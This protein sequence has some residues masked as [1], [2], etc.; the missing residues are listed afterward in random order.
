MLMSRYPRE[1]EAGQAEMS[2]R[3]A[4]I[5]FDGSVVCERCVVADGFGLRFRGL[6]GRRSLAADEGLLVTATSS[7][8]TTFMRFPID[9]LFLDGELRVVDVVA[10]LKPWRL[11]G[12]RRAKQVLELRAGEAARR[13][14]VAGTRLRLIEP[15]TA[16]AAA[17]A[18]GSPRPSAEAA[19]S[20]RVVVGAS[21][22]RFLRV[23]SFLLGR[24]GFSVAS[25]TGFADL[26][27]VVEQ[28]GADVV[29]LDT[30][31]SG[32]WTARAAAALEAWRTDVGVLVVCDES[33]ADLPDAIPKW[34]SFDR[35]VE[36]I[37]RVH[38]RDLAGASPA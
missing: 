9:A 30:S 3:E 29:V 32:R 36:E 17:A 24:N 15:A 31:G 13:G 2:R 25:A 14:V 37:R 10:E 7:I 12:R 38:A 6:M 8:Q 21:D 16:P 26:M 5:E 27:G 19:R 34:G 22:R 18:A 33:A 1:E 23:A 4:R 28:G 20:I 35:I 11:A